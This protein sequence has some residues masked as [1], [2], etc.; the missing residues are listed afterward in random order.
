[1][2]INFTN[3]IL[4]II[5]IIFI[6]CII[7]NLLNDNIISKNIVD[8]FSSSDEKN[9]LRTNLNNLES[10]NIDYKIDN[11]THNKVLYK[12]TIQEQAMHKF[13]FY[14]HNDIEY[15]NEYFF[16]LN[17]NTTNGDYKFLCNYIDGND[18][19]KIKF[20]NHYQLYFEI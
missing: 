14:T 18:N 16:L 9:Q 19:N 6:L 11:Y 17:N 7:N 8:K 5:S 2:K 20:L 13:W 15:E 3:I 10:E 12:N 1:M 4:I